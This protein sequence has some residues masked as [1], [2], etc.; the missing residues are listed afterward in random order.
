MQFVMPTSPDGWG[1][2]ERSQIRD[3]SLVF[4]RLCSLPTHSNDS[5]TSTIVGVFSGFSWTR[6]QR[7]R[8]EPTLVFF[9]ET[10]V[11]F[12]FSRTADIDELTSSVPEVRSWS[13]RNPCGL[14][15]LLILTSTAD[16]SGVSP[17]P[18]AIRR[19]HLLKLFGAVFVKSQTH[20]STWFSS[21]EALTSDS[22]SSVLSVAVY[23]SCIMGLS[24]TSGTTWLNALLS[25]APTSHTLRLVPSLFSMTVSSIIFRGCPWP[26][27]SDSCLLSTSEWPALSWPAV[28]LSMYGTN[29]KLS[30]TGTCP[31]CLLGAT[32]ACRPEGIK[33]WNNEGWHLLPHLGY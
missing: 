10:T 17:R 12:S 28:C 19:S 11:N 30:R 16:N 14:R 32:V 13:N 27:A 24:A 7:T 3:F 6:R 9:T 22:K 29:E 2:Q 5:S 18:Q 25:L 4:R 20:T 33:N 8:L 26:S 23:L 15:A 21:A 1:T 31:S